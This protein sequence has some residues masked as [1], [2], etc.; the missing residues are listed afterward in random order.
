MTN[1]QFEAIEKAIITGDEATL[2]QLLQVFREAPVDHAW[3]DERGNP[4]SLQAVDALANARF[5]ILRE[6]DFGSWERFMQFKEACSDAR[7]AV[8]KFE[9]A[10]DAIVTGDITTLERLLHENPGIVHERSM[11]F[12][13]A[14]LLH[15]TG[16]N[17]IEGYRQLAP[18]N[19]VDITN[20]L[21]KAGADVNAVAH[22][23]G[24][25]ATLGLVATSIHPQNAGVQ[26]PVMETLLNHG[27]ML[28]EEPEPGSPVSGCLANG[29][30]EA[31]E[32]FASRGARLD[33][34]AAAGIGRLD[35]VKTFFN[36]DGA[37]KFHSSR[38]R[39]SAGLCRACQFG[40]I[41]TVQFL[42]QQDVD[43]IAQFDGMQWAAFAGHADI[44]QLFLERGYLPLDLYNRW[45]GTALSAA[46]YGA[47]GNS[48]KNY[49]PVLQLL[50][51]AGANAN[52]FE[53]LKARVEQLMQRK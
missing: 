4:H 18:K 23:Y 41:E 47:G 44:V 26:I 49:L 6:H 14:T 53:G 42:L 43:V 8:A 1:E 29:R 35:V 15:Y 51:D 9:Q 52:A 25:D 12:H 7:S 17:G 32:F 27:A 31:A 36:D 46:V 28:Y 33:L 24:R 2:E 16:S 30:I 19:L 50:L 13:K 34:E 11:R 10:A 3:R 21:L 37:L 20:M 22:M 48:H 45:G 39:L 40:K 5:I 38:G